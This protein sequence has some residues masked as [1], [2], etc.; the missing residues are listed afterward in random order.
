MDDKFWMILALASAQK[1]DPNHAQILAQFLQQAQT[2][3]VFLT[4]YYLEK[5][6]NKNLQKL[7]QDLHHPPDPPPI[8]ILNPTLQHTQNA[9]LT[10][11]LM[12]CYPVIWQDGM[13]ISPDWQGLQRRIVQA[14]RK[15]ELLLQACKPTPNQRILDCTAGFGHDGLIL[16]S[17][18]AKVLMM[19]QNPLLA[20]LLKHEKRLQSQQKNWQALMD[21]IEIHHQDSFDYLENL[22]SLENLNNLDTK[23]DYKFDLIYLDPMFPEGS[24][25]GAKVNKRMQF[26]HYLYS[27]DRANARQ[28]NALTNLDFEKKWLNL[29][30]DQLHPNGRVVVKRP[31]SA[32]NF[33]Q[34][35]P[36]SSW[37]NAVIRLDVYEF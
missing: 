1:N 4:P 9:D 12:N 11:D 37:Q 5:I 35:D 16:A 18:G 21:R 34:L 2:E 23:L 15:S 17:T 27:R 28:S 6:N 3:Q 10:N 14:G 36:Q 29:A 13:K 24:Y 32:P 26:L 22:N 33:A 30:F 8:L 7:I 31:L 20:W 25:Q 19:E